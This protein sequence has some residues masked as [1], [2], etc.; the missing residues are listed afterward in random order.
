MVEEVVDTGFEGVGVEEPAAE[1][2]LNAEL[3]LFVA[4]AVERGEAG[5]CAEG[6]V[7]EV[8]GAVGDR[9]GAAAG[10]GR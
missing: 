7:L 10:S 9:S 4:F 5:A 2:D 1:G 6:E 3:V 8:A